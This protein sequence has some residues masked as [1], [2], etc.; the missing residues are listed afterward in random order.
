[1]PRTW[2]SDLQTIFEAYK[3]RHTLDLYLA[4]D[5]VLHLSRGRVIR[6][7]DEENVEYENY[8]RSVDDLSSSLE[9]S[10]DRISIKCQNVNSELGFNIASDLR[11]LDYATAD[12]GKVYQ[13][14]RNPALIEDIPQ[15]FR[16]VLANAEADEQNF[17]IELIVDYESLGLILASRGL[18]LKCAWLYKNGVECQSASVADSCALTRKACKRNSYEFGFGGWEDFALPVNSAPGSGTGG[19]GIGGCFTGDTLVLTPDGEIPI[20]EMANRKREGKNSIYSFDKKTGE[21]ELDRIEAC[22][23]QEMTGFFTLTFGNAEINVSAAHPFF[24]N[25]NQ[26]TRAD[27]FKLGQTTRKFDYFTRLWFDSQLRNIKWNSDKT[28]TVYNLKVKNNATYFANG[29][30]VSNAKDGN[31]IILV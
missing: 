10:V 8:I 5:S 4:D 1:M 23:A 3:L 14:V 20:S 25:L 11:L 7:I 22:W 24:T 29:F 27:N 19:G 2:S 31:E 15:M 9:N 16:G 18:S 30:A 12:Y 6:E 17:N 13:S 21:V 28:E 26:F